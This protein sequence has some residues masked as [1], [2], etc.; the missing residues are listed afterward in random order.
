MSSRGRWGRKAVF[1][2]AAV[3]ILTLSLY[4]LPASAVPF[5][6]AAFNG[7][8]TGNNL[9]VDALSMGTGAD[10][11]KVAN[12]TEAFTGSAVDSTGIKAIHNEMN[13]LV[14]PAGSKTYGRGSGVEL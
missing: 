6:E 10:E 8:A 9:Y 7:Y 3:A 5:N 14:A 13:R 2:I 12:V 4:V 11:V 1:A